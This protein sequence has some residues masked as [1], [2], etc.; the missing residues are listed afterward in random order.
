MVYDSLGM[1]IILTRR[2]WFLI[3]RPD[4]LCSEINAKGCVLQDKPKIIDP[5]AFDK[6][7]GASR[8]CHS[9]ADSL[10]V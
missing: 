8:I 4:L 9:S 3:F 5:K 7:R 6:T 1:S 10:M 2:L